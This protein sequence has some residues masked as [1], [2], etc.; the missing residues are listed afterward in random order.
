[1]LRTQLINWLAAIHCYVG[2]TVLHKF[3]YVCFFGLCISYIG[4]FVKQKSI[5]VSSGASLY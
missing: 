4:L 2:V 5:V 1:M 3:V